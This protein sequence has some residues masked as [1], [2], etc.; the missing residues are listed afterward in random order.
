[1]E[2]AWVLTN[3]ASG[4]TQQTLAI[5][6]QGGIPWLIRLLKSKRLPVTEQVLILLNTD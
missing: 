6:K 5:V 4:T 1:M 2:A 3:I